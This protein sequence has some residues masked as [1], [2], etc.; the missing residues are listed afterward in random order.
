MR[1]YDILQ[2]RV[3]ETVEG[4]IIQLV[5]KSIEDKLP[6]N[7]TIESSTDEELSKAIDKLNASVE[8]KR[9]RTEND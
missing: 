7:K 5:R 1:D 6:K 9:C 3:E 4:A 2:E 8:K